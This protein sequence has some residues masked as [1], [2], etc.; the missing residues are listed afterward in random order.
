MR[1]NHTK[2]SENFTHSTT[3]SCMVRYRLTTKVKNQKTVPSRLRILWLGNPCNKLY[4]IRSISMEMGLAEVVLYHCNDHIENLNRKFCCT[5]GSRASNR[6][7]SLSI[8]MY[9]THTKCSE[10]FNHSTTRSGMISPLRCALAD[11]QKSNPA[12]TSKFILYNVGLDKN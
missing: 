12:R 7:S 11:S 3:R 6:E 8:E 9:D 5:I 4:L 2:Y 10:S 1:S